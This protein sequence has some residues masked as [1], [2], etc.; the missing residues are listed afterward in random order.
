MDA[1]GATTIDEFVLRAYGHQGQAGQ[2]GPADPSAARLRNTELYVQRVATEARYQAANHRKLPRK[3]GSRLKFFD[4]LACNKCIPVC[5]NDAN[6]D[7]RMPSTPQVPVKMTRQL[8][9][10]ADFCNDCGNCDVFCPED[11]GPYLLK[12]RLFVNRQR[13][14]K[15]APRDAVLIEPDATTGRFDGEEVRV[16]V[17]QGAGDDPR[18]QALQSLRNA[19]LDPA[20]V[21]YVSEYL[22][23]M[24]AGRTG[25]AH[26][27]P[28]ESGVGTR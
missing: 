8:V 19:L 14:L 26:T 27:R 15:D 10:F 13:W 2:A 7:V 9:N 6:F 22:R 24:A 21:N 5:P 12:P 18:A 25:P 28:D 20:E 1:V 3:V 23:G 4:C 17:A 11:G 16:P